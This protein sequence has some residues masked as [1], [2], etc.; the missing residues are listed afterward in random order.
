MEELRLEQIQS[1]NGP[2]LLYGLD[3]N[4]SVWALGSKGQVVGSGEV[5]VPAG[6]CWVRIPMAKGEQ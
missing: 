4:G 3:E 2:Y 6:L 5:D 1:G